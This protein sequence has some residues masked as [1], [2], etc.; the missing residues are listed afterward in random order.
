MMK[1]KKELF[2]IIKPDFE[3]SDQRGQLKQLVHDGWK[4][5]NVLV[6]NAGVI[7]GI[8]YHKISRE[9]FY[10]LS[11]S[12][13]VRFRNGE[14]HSE[15]HFVAND[16]FVVLPGTVHELS[17]PENCVMVQMYDI[18]VEKED[19]SKDIFVGEV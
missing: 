2:Q 6:T 15:R 18:P 17:F 1:E 7:R 5:V 16:F 9:A 19:G 12:V 13:D 10:L 3:Y 11:G 14:N 4:Q 8:H